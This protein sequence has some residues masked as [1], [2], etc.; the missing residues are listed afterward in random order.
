MMRHDFDWTSKTFEH[1]E[2]GIVTAAHLAIK[3]LGVAHKHF[4]VPMS[5]Y[6]LSGWNKY[7]HY[8]HHI[9]ELQE[10]DGDEIWIK[11]WIVG[12]WLG[13]TE[14]VFQFEPN[15][16][17]E[18]VYQEIKWTDQTDWKH[19]HKRGAIYGIYLTVTRKAENWTAVFSFR[20]DD[21]PHTDK[22]HDLPVREALCVSIN[23]DERKVEE[24]L[25]WAYKQS[26]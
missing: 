7:D 17:M 13:A 22:L 20:L 16:F 15:E 26:A 1:Q 4:L 14:C 6:D 3:A 2:K 12:Q 10:E 24:W 8:R 18:E 5:E 21:A 23:G 19:R 25:D 9:E 11:P